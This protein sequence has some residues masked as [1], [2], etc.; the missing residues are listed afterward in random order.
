[1]R[2]T[3]HAFGVEFQNPVLLAA[4]TCGF[5]VE[6]TDVL[7]IEELGGFVT[8]SITL[9]PRLGNPAPRVAEFDS[10]MMNSV[11]LA[12]PGLARARDEKLPWIAANVRRARVLVSV[13][14]HTL[15]EYFR[16]IEGLDAAD[17]F[18][19]FEIN[20]SCPN[21]ARRDGVPFALDP[22]AVTEIMSGCRARTERPILAK[23]APNDPSLGVTVRRAEEAGADAITL[24]NTMPGLLLDPT[25]GQ[26]RLGQG[27]GGVS[28]PA[29]R[30]V[31]IRAVREARS[32]T[33]LPLL[34]VGGV[35]A[36]E[37]AVAY[38]RAGANLVQMG[39]ATFAA[40]RAA[41]DLI[42]GLERWGRRQGVAAWD[43]L[44]GAGGET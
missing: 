10:G 5:G 22:D 40:P 24:V 3:T 23:L 19:G 34:G 42:S 43:D 30:P 25:S 31:G 11:G 9:E 44:R 16:L 32:N 18:V 6:L 28:G 4:G 15:D 29:L 33:G 7:D 41:T 35:L 12:N 17:G 21:D 39:T 1:V 13:A 20:L 14:G 37:D 8:K 26:P 27:A 2:L 36:T 38:G